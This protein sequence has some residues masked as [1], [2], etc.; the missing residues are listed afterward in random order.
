MGTRRRHQLDYTSSSDQSCDTVIY[1]GSDPDHELTDHERPPST[2]TSPGGRASG[3]LDGGSSA[4]RSGLP[5][6][7]GGRHSDGELLATGARAPRRSLST[8]PAWRSPPPPPRSVQ[9]GAET[10]IDGPSTR[11]EQWVDGPP[12]FRHVDDVEVTS[13]ER[14]PSGSDLFLEEIAEETEPRRSIA[15]ASAVPKN[16]D[17]E[18]AVAARSVAIKHDHSV[19]QVSLPAEISN[20]QVTVADV[21][22][23]VVEGGEVTEM[24]GAAEVDRSADLGVEQDLGTSEVADKCPGVELRPVA[25]R[26]GL[27][28][29]VGEKRGASGDD[30][31]QPAAAV[32]RR[33]KLD[34]DALLLANRE[35]IYELQ[36]DEELETGSR[37]SLLQLVCGSDDDW[38]TCGTQPR[39]TSKCTQ[40]NSFTDLD[41]CL[42][43]LDAMA[44]TASELPASKPRADVERSA[45]EQRAN[46]EDC[47]NEESA[48]NNVGSEEEPGKRVWIRTQDLL[49]ESLTSCLQS[50]SR[51]HDGAP[52][53]VTSRTD[54]AAVATPSPSRTPRSSAIPTPVSSSPSRVRRKPPPIPVRSS[55][56]TQSADPSANGRATST[57]LTGGSSTSCSIIHQKTPSDSKNGSASRGCCST[58]CSAAAR[59]AEA[60]TTGIAA[61]AAAATSQPRGE[62]VLTGTD[63][64]QRGPVPPPSA[65]TKGRSRIALPCRRDKKN[66]HQPDIAASPAGA[67]AAAT[68]AVLALVSP[69]R[70]VTR[71]RTSRGAD[72]DV[73]SSVVSSEPRRALS[74]AAGR[75]WSGARRR[76]GSARGA[77]SEVEASSGY[78]S[79]MRDSEDV[80][81][82]SSAS[83]CQSPLRLK[84]NKMFRKKGLITTILA[85]AAANNNDG[86]SNRNNDNLT[87]LDRAHIERHRALIISECS[88]F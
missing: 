42:R 19:T 76:A 55:S 59:E 69:Y 33:A 68:S 2:R 80:T 27:D 87:V 78:E 57:N 75:L 31:E 79:M 23:S 9:A 86:N 39:R 16:V 10:W 64:K 44:V 54:S 41:A 85:T 48:E 1:V 45:A 32:E 84:A 49:H 71:P 50:N 61:A 3:E 5:R 53:S 6:A 24:S 18:F 60:T 46:A 51:D 35:S 37:E 7:I 26:T 47:A 77:R 67:P 21:H 20:P 4:R 62:G 73:S 58:D 65:S 28:V 74:A 63:A 83:E 81:A 29:D 11:V 72:S 25:G 38:S 8:R 14:R 13:V 88:L 22:Q 30:A 17:D 43:D 36:M 56:V 82:T 52:T 34:I 12:E 70:S 40:S 15:D 66:K